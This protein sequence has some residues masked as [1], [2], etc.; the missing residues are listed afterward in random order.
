MAFVF[1][2]RKR[3]TLIF[4]IVVSAFFYGVIVGNKE[5]FPF[6]GIRYIKNL[7]TNKNIH[8]PILTSS[9]PIVVYLNGN[10]AT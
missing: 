3:F 4:C 1:N 6:S 5:I 9:D 2:K 10:K 7:V 8:K